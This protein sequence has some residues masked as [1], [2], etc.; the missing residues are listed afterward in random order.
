VVEGIDLAFTTDLPEPEVFDYYATWLESNG[1]SQQAP[2]EAMITPPHQRW[3][4][5]GA[6][7]RLEIPGLDEAGHTQVWVQVTYL[8]T[9]ALPQPTSAG[10]DILPEPATPIPTPLLRS[11]RRQRAGWDLAAGRMAPG[12]T[13]ACGCPSPCL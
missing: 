11:R 5:D 1:W 13:S 6:E 7:L 8:T 4:K 12:P 2:T 3:R 10:A 9:D